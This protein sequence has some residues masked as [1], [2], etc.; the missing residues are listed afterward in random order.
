M[1]CEYGTNKAHNKALCH[2]SFRLR[3]KPLDEALIAK[4]NVAGM[5]PFV[6]GL[7]SVASPNGF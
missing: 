5:I 1:P 4:S 7:A 3:S 2:N 6:N